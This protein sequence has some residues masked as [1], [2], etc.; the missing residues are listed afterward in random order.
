VTT[1]GADWSAEEWSCKRILAGKTS[2]HPKNFMAIGVQDQLNLLTA[3]ISVFLIFA[4]Q[5]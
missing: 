3:C 2:F 1:G 5:H 4:Q